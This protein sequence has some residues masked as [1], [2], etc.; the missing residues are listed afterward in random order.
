M[1]G[2]RCDPDTITW[3]ESGLSSNILLNDSWWQTETGWHISGN[4][5]G[6]QTFKT[7][8]GSATKPLP[9]FD[10][11]ILD[12]V[13]MEEIIEPNSMGKIVCKLPMPPSFMS[14]LWKHDEAFLEKYISADSMYYI[15]GDSGF[16]DEDNY[17]SIMTRSDDMIK[18]AGHRLST[19]RIEE[20]I[21]Y[22]KYVVESA[23]VGKDDELKAEVPFAFIVAKKSVISE[24][25]IKLLIKDVDSQVVS[26]IGAISRLAGIIIVDKLP[27]TR[28]G[29]TLRIILKKILNKVKYTLPP[30]IEDSTVIDDIIEI[31]KERK[32][33]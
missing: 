33:I 27:K 18:V 11:R 13:T 7:K 20:C 32:L 12:E 10:V 23:V 17:L 22:S 4:N 14:T 30:T 15:T 3:L 21:N 25:D 29:K 19:G 6:I 1:A 8:P 2:E 24:D 9:G 26:N 31:L 28:S 5:L 16:F